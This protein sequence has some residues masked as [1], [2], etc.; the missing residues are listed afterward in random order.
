MKRAIVPALVLGLLSLASLGCRDRRDSPGRET[1]THASQELDCVK[2]SVHCGR[3]PSVRLAESGSL[4]AAFEHERH[5]YV[6]H[7][8]N[9]G[10]S[11]STPARVTVEEEDIETNGENRPKIEIAGQTVFV[12]WT[13]KREGMFTADI[14][15]SRSLDGGQTFETPRTINDDGLVI[16]HR[17]ESL[18]LDEAGH[19]YLVWVDKRDLEAAKKRD[20][21][22]RGAAIY[23]TM[24]TDGGET[25]I[26]NRRVADHACECCRIATASQEEDGIAILWRHV[27][28]GQIRDHAFATLGVDGV[29]SDL[30]RATEDGWMIEACPHHGPAMWR[31][32]DVYH[33]T[34]FT[35]AG[36]QPLALYGR[37]DPSS[38]IVE[39]VRQVAKSVAAHPFILGV[40][41][42]LFLVWKQQAE[43]GAEIRL[44]VSGDAGESWA[45]ETTLATT[46][47]VSDHP[48]LLKRA[49]V[50]HL[51]WHTADEG[52][53]I[54]PVASGGPRSASEGTAG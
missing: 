17:F 22:Y 34:W 16:G 26:A 36:E 44:N 13:R 27:F 7:S 4:Y 38:G 30:Q 45:E 53:R 2:V 43:N 54:L 33:L 8:E 50:A 5:T 9:F 32:G 20:E 51:V 21:E 14:R 15:F 47:G 18:H 39:H 3:V 48:F 46:A 35:G 23:Y 49:G 37:F 1:G 24:S 40:K 11:W 41:E 12:S 10:E 52:L 28:E 25:F 31:S 6:S 19:V 29:T 42:D